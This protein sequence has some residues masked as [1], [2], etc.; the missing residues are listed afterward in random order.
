MKMAVPFPVIMKE[1]EVDVEA[2]EGGRGPLEKGSLQNPRSVLLHPLPGPP[3]SSVTT[4]PIGQLALPRHSFPSLTQL[5]EW[6]KELRLD[7]KARAWHCH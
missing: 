7:R 4:L 3:H 2:W 6:Q 5:P 1:V